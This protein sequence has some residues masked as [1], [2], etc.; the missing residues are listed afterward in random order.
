MDELVQ[1]IS[2][3]MYKKEGEEDEIGFLTK[4]RRTKQV[5][6]EKLNAVNE[7][8]IKYRELHKKDLLIEKFF[9]DLFYGFRFEYKLEIGYYKRLRDGQS[10][11]DIADELEAIDETHDI[12]CSIV[13]GYHGCVL[14]E[15]L[16][17]LLW[18]SD[19]GD[20]DGYLVKLKA[21]RELDKNQSDEI[22]N[23]LEEYRKVFDDSKYV[24]KPF[25]Y[26]FM[27]FYETISD[28]E[29]LYQGKKLGDI[30]TF[31]LDAERKIRRLLC[32]N[33]IIK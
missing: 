30:A 31:E 26:A 5:D 9:M 14:A 8:L 12:M 33:W 29:K 28:N 4:L 11:D 15:K 2:D 32:E 22:L 13:K 25:V 6:K 27:D 18:K 20:E 7:N 17:E 3:L 10:V 21:G 24:E 16:V 23:V 1:K 19:S